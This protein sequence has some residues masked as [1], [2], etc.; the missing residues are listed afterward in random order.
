MVIS[1]IGLLISAPSVFTTD[2]SNFSQRGFVERMETT[3]LTAS[4]I[5]LKNCPQRFPTAKIM[6]MGAAPVIAAKVATSVSTI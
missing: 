6:P 5:P 1:S 4:P 3:A 2:G